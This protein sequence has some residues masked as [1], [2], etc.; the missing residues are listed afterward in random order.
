MQIKTT[1]TIAAFIELGHQLMLLTS[2]K[3]AKQNQEAFEKAV[4]LAFYKNG[5]F[6]RGNVIKAL[7]SISVMLEKESLEK[8]IATY[9]NTISK[10][11]NAKKVGV[12]MAGNVPAVGF[13]DF[14]CVLLSG[15]TFVGK[16]SSDDAVLLPFLAE[17]LTEIEP[18]LKARIH[19][20]DAKLAD[21]DIYIATGSN[22]SSR[23]FAYYFADKPHLIRK[24]RSSIAVLSGNETSEELQCL[25]KDVFDYFG[26]GCRSVS[27]LFVPKQYSFN[28]FFENIFNH[29]DVLQNNKY[30][31]N[32]EYNRT[33]YLMGSTPLLDNNF[34]LLK[35]D[36]ALASPVAV[37]F[38]EYYTSAAELS[39]R[40]R[41]DA[42][43]LQC[44]VS[45]M[46]GLSNTVAFG[47]T[48]CPALSDYADG[49]DT[50]NFL[51]Q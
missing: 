5:W 44:V 49:V 50:M 4:E 39:Q 6:T 25:G 37:L 38:Y 11:E 19:F 23:Y 43:Q 15:N 22:N 2:R 16:C 21:A 30:M 32:Y 24:N 45:K 18:R 48:Q 28:L 41:M 29:A 7:E 12:I 26:L 9:V 20:V 40:L 10:K 42:P 14:L 27:K 33:I 31:N 13:H 46:A 35:E 36:I 51:L 47:Q 8:W 1:D 34:L 3:A 17:L